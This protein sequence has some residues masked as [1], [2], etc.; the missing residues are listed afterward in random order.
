LLEED[1]RHEDHKLEFN[2]E[3]FISLIKELADGNGMSVGF[4]DIGDGVDN[5][6]PTLAAII[7]CREV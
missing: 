1:V 4:F 3:E 6:K 5:L 2:K 7:S